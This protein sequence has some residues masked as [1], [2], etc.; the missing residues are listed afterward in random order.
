MVQDRRKAMMYRPEGTAQG[1][2]SSAQCKCRLRTV[3]PRETGATRVLVAAAQCG[4]GLACGGA[5]GWFGVRGKGWD[6]FGRGGWSRAGHRAQVAATKKKKT[7]RAK[8]ALQ[9]QRQLGGGEWRRG[10]RNGAVG[11][12]GASNDDSGGA[13]VYV[14]MC[15]YMYARVC[16][17][18]VH[19]NGSAVR[20]SAV[21]SHDV[22]PAPFSRIEPAALLRG[23]HHSCINLSIF[24]QSFGRRAS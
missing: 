10:E 21:V 23:A 2:R 14:C 16:T 5:T 6:C 7:I 3:P 24:G 20:C 8:T 11:K 9:R 19:V 17:L 13:Y 1:A 4:A 18:G 22:A 15:M 12:N